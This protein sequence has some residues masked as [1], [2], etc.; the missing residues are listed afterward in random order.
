MQTE[1][2]SRTAMP[3]DDAPVSPVAAADWTSDLILR[4]QREVIIQHG[5][6][7]Y[8]LRLTASNKLILTK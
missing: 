7:R 4:G 1:A 2:S 5:A 3:C 6:E 8:R